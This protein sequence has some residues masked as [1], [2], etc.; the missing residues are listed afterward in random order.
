MKA[1]NPR[2][3]FQEGFRGV[4]GGVRITSGPVET[5]LQSMAWRNYTRNTGDPVNHDQVLIEIY[6]F[7]GLETVLKFRSVPGER[8]SKGVD[9]IIAQPEAS[10]LAC[11]LSFHS[12]E[13]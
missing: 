9:V 5:Y 1:L 10:P 6:G 4:D 8:P 11:I 12:S 3:N 7:R 13:S 2:F